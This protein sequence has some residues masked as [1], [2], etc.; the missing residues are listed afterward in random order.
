[1][2]NDKAS[3]LVLIGTILN[4]RGVGYTLDGDLN[5]PGVQTIE[6]RTERHTKISGYA[7]LSCVLMFK[8]G[9]LEGIDLGED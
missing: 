2:T 5:N 1:M 9:V 7:G 8:D 6:F 4:E 3:D